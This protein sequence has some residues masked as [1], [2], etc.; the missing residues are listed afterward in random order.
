MS[1]KY[2]STQYVDAHSEALY[3]THYG[4]AFTEF[5]VDPK[6]PA[7]FPQ[8]VWK[9][10]PDRVDGRPYLQWSSIVSALDI[11]E[12]S[13]TLSRPATS[14]TSSLRLKT[15]MFPPSASGS[16]TFDGG[17][18][19]GYGNRYVLETTI[20]LAASPSPPTKEYVVAYTGTQSSGLSSRCLHLQTSV[21]VAGMD[22]RLPNNVCFFF[23]RNG[24]SIWA[25]EKVLRDVSPYFATLLSSGFSEGMARCQDPPQADLSA[26]FEPLEYLD[27][28]EESDQVVAGAVK[29]NSDDFALASFKRVDVT[30][31]MYTTY[32]AVLCWIGT[33]HID[34]ARLNSSKCYNR[35]SPSTKSGASAQP[36]EY[37][38]LPT[39]ASPKSVYRLASLLELPALAKLAHENFESQLTPQNAAYELFTDIADTYPEIRDSAL[40]CVVKNWKEVVVS[41][42]YA[43]VEARAVSGTGV[44]GMT[45]LLLGKALMQ[46]WVK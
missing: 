45:G 4:Y 23:P 16:I 19:L 20:V 1:L 29:A 32:R 46:E 12:G 5:Q 35:V 25:N 40:A 21:H 38:S 28:D 11:V 13:I 44:D 34:F 41:A 22:A 18:R 2:E 15:G 3:S 8:G 10:R 33:N 37:H 39:P 30:E 42:A 31:E 27:S 9:I 43:D 26:I 7:P 36:R 24:R 14:Q 17:T 6:F